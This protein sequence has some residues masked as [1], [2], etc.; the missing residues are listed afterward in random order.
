MNTNLPVI[1][2]SGE[3][4]TEVLQKAVAANCELIVK[5]VQ[6]TDLIKEIHYALF[7]KKYSDVL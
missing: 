2:V 6:M 3:T 5:P 4:S 1:I 7:S